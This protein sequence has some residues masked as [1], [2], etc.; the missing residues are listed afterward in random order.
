MAEGPTRD[1][2]SRALFANVPPDQ[3]AARRLFVGRDRSKAALVD[4]SDRRGKP[5]L[6]L[7]V[8]SLGN[9]SISFLDENGVVVRTIQ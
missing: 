9:A 3:V 6:R 5:R 4:L 1:S 8:D 7:M 2:V